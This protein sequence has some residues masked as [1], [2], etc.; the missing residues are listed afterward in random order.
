MA[1]IYII[2]VAVLFSAFTYAQ[3]AID[4][5]AERNTSNYIERIQSNIELSE[6]EISIVKELFTNHSKSWI[7]LARD[8]K[9][10]P[11]IKERR[12]E[13]SVKYSLALREAVGNKRAAEIQKAS[14]PKKQQ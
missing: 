9:D 14:V 7:V 4:V 1:K 10:S 2:L 5:A 11:D 3:D 12:R 8:H 6:E 13:L